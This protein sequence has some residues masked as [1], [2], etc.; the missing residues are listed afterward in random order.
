MNDILTTAGT[1][2]VAAVWTG[3]V[4][5]IFSVLFFLMDAV[6]KVVRTKVSVDATVGLGYADGQV[7]P[8]GVT[9]L[10]CTALYAFPRTAL[11]GAILLTGY[12]GGAVASNIRAGS[13]LFNAMFPIIFAVIAWVGLALREPRIQA[14]ILNR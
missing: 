2:N 5:S 9:L 8:I 11:L 3:R 14:L 13:P 1:T 12:L 7:L 10:I 4:L 6:M